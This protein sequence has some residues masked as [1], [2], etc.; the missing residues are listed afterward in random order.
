MLV[1]NIPQNEAGVAKTEEAPPARTEPAT[2]TEE[3]AQAKTEAE[4]KPLTW[5]NLAP[6]AARLVHLVS[7]SAHFDYV[8]VG[9]SATG[10]LCGDIAVLF[11]VFCVW[12]AF[13][14]YTSLEAPMATTLMGK[15]EKVTLVRIPMVR[16]RMMEPEGRTRGFLAAKS[17]NLLPS[18]IVEKRS[19]GPAR[20][21]A[22]ST[23]IMAMNAVTTGRRM[24][25]GGERGEAVDATI[26]SVGHD[27]IA[28]TIVVGRAPRG[29]V[30]HWDHPLQGPSGEVTVTG[31]AM[32]HVMCGVTTHATGVVT[33]HA[34]GITST[35]AMRASTMCGAKTLVTLGM[36]AQGCRR[37]D[38]ALYRQS[39]WS[40]PCTLR[41]RRSF[42]IQV[43]CLT[44]RCTLGGLWCGGGL[45]DDDV[46]FFLGGPIEGHREAK[47]DRSP[48][49]YSGGY[50]ERRV[51][52][53]VR[54]D[55][56]KRRRN[57]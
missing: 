8:S 39:L 23:S 13:G 47:R 20:M 12:C 11:V 14:V 29:T 2:K 15:R 55:D 41:A 16:K 36:T 44:V 5:G 9:I 33:D 52:C 7:C 51:E 34:T 22:E 56:A 40:M 6:D 26:V 19:T 50:P 17:P 46:F 1:W 31:A 3:A 48:S 49:P 18:A 42:A 32:V 24:A 30:V 35:S 10:F 28:G 21:T 27:G 43:V 25:T 4:D 45:T 38:A 53:S 57:R 54:D 37:R